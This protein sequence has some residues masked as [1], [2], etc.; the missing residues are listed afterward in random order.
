[1]FNVTCRVLR[2]LIVMIVSRRD[3]ST[4]LS[5]TPTSRPA[6]RPVRPPRRAPVLRAGPVGGH[7]RRVASR[8]A[9]CVASRATYRRVA[10][11]SFHSHCAALPCTTVR[12]RTR[13]AAVMP[14]RTEYMGCTACTSRTAAYETEQRRAANT[15]KCGEE[16]VR[17]TTLIASRI[18]RA[19][20]HICEAAGS[21][22][23]SNR[24]LGRQLCQLD[25]IGS[26]L[27][28]MHGNDERRLKVRG[29]LHLA[30]ERL[31]ARQHA[32]RDRWLTADGVPRARHGATPLLDCS[33]VVAFSRMCSAMSAS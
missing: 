10:L 12:L 21:P 29:R 28:V 33:V 27:E 31:E 6:S 11:A 26:L 16:L 3:G 13:P 24:Q 19:S 4:I 7:V 1:M 8:P 15:E 9:S 25:A 32:P 2:W 23:R 22:C 5:L 18:D 17:W 20:S 14:M 30:R